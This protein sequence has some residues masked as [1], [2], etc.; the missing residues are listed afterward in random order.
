MRA[1]PVGVRTFKSVPFFFLE[2]LG[3]SIIAQFILANGLYHDDAMIHLYSLGRLLLLSGLAVISLISTHLVLLRNNHDEAVLDN[4]P[5]SR[6][7]ASNPTQSRQTNTNTLLSDG[8]VAT[9]GNNLAIIAPVLSCG[10]KKCLFPVVNQHNKNSDKVATAGTTGT[11]ILNSKGYL[12]AN[13]GAKQYQRAFD[14]WRYAKYLEYHYGLRQ[15]LLEKP[16]QIDISADLAK[17][18]LNVDFSD[19]GRLGYQ[20]ST[21]QFEPGPAIA[22]PVQIV[23]EPWILVGCYGRYESSVQK[24]ERF[25]SKLMKDVV[26]VDATATTRPPSPATTNQFLENFAHDLNQTEAI[27]QESEVECL[28]HDFQL[29]LDAEGH[30]VHMD[31][32]RCLA[33]VRRTDGKGKIT[34]DDQ[35]LCKDQMRSLLKKSRQQILGG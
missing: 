25:V 23:A 26:E 15:T 20:N 29:I 22:Q 27:L 24:L 14:A 17:N 4:E 11:S 19:S 18:H 12:I 5:P 16:V 1:N 10:R 28:Y 35:R 6:G 3:R 33:Q 21:R 13:G 30:L 34:R 8:P 31:L 2:P 32:D 7:S 9:L